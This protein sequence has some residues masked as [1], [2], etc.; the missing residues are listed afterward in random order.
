M[1]D[2]PSR[3]RLAEE[4]RGW[5]LDVVPAIYPLRLRV[6]PKL[7]LCLCDG[8]TSPEGGAF[9]YW[10]EPG[11][12]EIERK[13]RT[14]SHVRSQP[15]RPSYALVPYTTSGPRISLSLVDPSP[16]YDRTRTSPRM[17]LFE[18]RQCW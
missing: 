13:T 12:A 6:T 10:R 5:K 18:D 9:G 16:S 11:R 7:V 14:A 8:P 2:N 4:T 3:S 1:L 15:Q 17:C